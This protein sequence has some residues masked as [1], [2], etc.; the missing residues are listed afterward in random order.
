MLILMVQK[1]NCELKKPETTKVRIDSNCVKSKRSLPMLIY[2]VA[3]ST[4]IAVALAVPISD[5]VNNLFV[6]YNFEM[7]YNMVN[8]AEESFPGPLVRLKLARDG[9]TSLKIDD[10]KSLSKNFAG[11][12]KILFTRVGFYMIIES[13]LDALGFLSSNIEQRN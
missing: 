2:P 6:S 12:N 3:T 13:R 7:N 8:R 10:A 11:I 4:G 5:D 1:I 9:K